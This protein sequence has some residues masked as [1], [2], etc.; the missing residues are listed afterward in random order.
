MNKDKIAITISPI[1]LKHIDSLVEQRHFQS[2]SHAITYYLEKGLNERAIDKGV[3]LLSKEHQKLSLIEYKNKTF[4]ENQVEFLKSQGI[5]DIVILTQKSE[6]LDK[7]QQKVLDIKII[8][9]DAKSTGDALYSLKAELSQKAFL[10]M[11]G[12]TYNEFNLSRMI[13]KHKEYKTIATI[14]LVDKDNVANCG[15]ALLD[16]NLIIDFEE[17]PYEPKSHIVNAGVY[18]FEPEIFE[19]LSKKVVNIEREV[20]PELAKKGQLSGYFT[21]GHY[22]HIGEK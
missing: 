1:I 20:L 5:N 19:Y 15:V 3:I 16:G 22:V 2:R 14:G 21:H 18:I 12:D 7:I 8:Q 10:V 11:S 17:H 13:A 6:I 4:I 9:K